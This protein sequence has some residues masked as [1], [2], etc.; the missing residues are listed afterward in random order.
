[1]RDT[2]IRGDC[3]EVMK[4]IPNKSIDM[5]LCD[6]PYGTTACKWDAIL[7]FFDLWEQYE[8]V[9][10]ANG[11]IILT[12]SQ[13]FTSALIMSNPTIYRYNWVWNKVGISNPMLA[14]KQPLR[15]HEDICVFYKKPPLYN[16][17][18]AEG[19]QWNRGGKREHKTDTLGSSILINN[20]SDKSRLKYPK[21]IIEFPNTNKTKNT[22]PT[23]KPVTLFEYLIKTYTNEGETVLDNCIGSGTTAIAALNT[24]R[25]FIGIEKEL[26]YVDISRMRLKGAIG[27]LYG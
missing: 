19:K 17:Q 27:S 21:T 8:R 18:M 3:L 6:L 23:Q 1:M 10:K 20:G 25:H 7:P 5:I 13:P 24:G 15:Q 12:A 22:H 4:D 11:A 14:K 16:P 9:I 2:I 26:K